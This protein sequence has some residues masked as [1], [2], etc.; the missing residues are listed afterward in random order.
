MPLPRNAAATIFLAASS[1]IAC[2]HP[3]RAQNSQHHDGEG[4]SPA[5]RKETAQPGARATIPAAE[6]A[7]VPMCK[8][9]Q[10]SLGTDAENGNFNG[11]SHSGTLLVL[12]NL[13]SAACR[14]PAIPE[15]S[16]FDAKHPLAARAELPGGAP[17]HPGP[18]VAPVIVAAGA[19]LTASLR[20]VSG[21]VY[22]DSVCLDPTR[23]T[24]AIAGAQLST[25]MAGHLCGDRAKGISYDLSH[26]A[27][28]PVYS[29][30]EAA[31]DAEET[32]SGGRTER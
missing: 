2:G 15:I 25:P 29:P 20:W 27:P 23:L 21:P 11:M 12:R 22:A 28:D 14:V 17:M 7:R 8:P 32:G 24:L 6:A 19:E 5:A 4:Q 18:A 16:F 1:L 26:F 31:E 3:S 30:E 13:G 9:S 10:L